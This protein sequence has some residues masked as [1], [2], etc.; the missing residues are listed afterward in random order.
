MMTI[1]RAFNALCL[2]ALLGGLGWLCQGCTGS[3]GT[4]VS[5]STVRRVGCAVAV[6]ACALVERVCAA[7]AGGD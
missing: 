1:E 2:A 3:G 4:Q 5:G 7:T 6:P